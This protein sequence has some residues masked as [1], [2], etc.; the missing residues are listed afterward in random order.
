MELEDKPFLNHNYAFVSVGFCWHCVLKNCK[1]RPPL[2]GVSSYILLEMNLAS[3]LAVPAAELLPF[4]SPF[5]SL[6]PFKAPP[7]LRCRLL[8]LLGARLGSH[9]W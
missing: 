9:S 5:G 2:F 7:T 3:H 1:I 6:L 8:M 4:C